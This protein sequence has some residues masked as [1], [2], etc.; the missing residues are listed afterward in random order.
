MISNGSARVVL[1]GK[2]KNKSRYKGRN[3]ILAEVNPTEIPKEF[4]EKISL[5]FK[6]GEVVDFNTDKLK[7]NFTMDDMQ[8]W[9]NRIDTQETITK[10]EVALDL[11]LIYDTLEKDSEN[12]LSKYF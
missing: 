9:L 1:V 8:S 5:T 4:I 7:E 11:D 3:N 6:S 2:S 12:F 10:V